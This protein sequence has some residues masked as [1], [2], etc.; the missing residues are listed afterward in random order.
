MEVIMSEQEFD[1]TNNIKKGESIIRKG[2]NDV[3][4]V[5]DNLKGNI[6]T[7]TANGPVARE[8]GSS[9]VWDWAYVVRDHKWIP[10]KLTPKQE[11]TRDIVK[12]RGSNGYRSSS[13]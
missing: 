3:C 1:Y 4:V 7:I 8:T 5:A 2:F 10:I 6:R 13:A 11:K 12:G 9:Y